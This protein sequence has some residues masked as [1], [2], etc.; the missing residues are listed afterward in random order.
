MGRA[1]QDQ[2]INDLL[3]WRGKAKNNYSGKFAHFLKESES[4]DVDIETLSRASITF[5]VPLDFFLDFAL[6][7]ESGSFE[8]DFSEHQQFINQGIQN[9]L[10]DRERR[11]APATGKDLEDFEANYT[12]LFPG[13]VLRRF[14]QRLREY[15]KSQTQDDALQIAVRRIVNAPAQHHHPSASFKLDL[16]DAAKTPPNLDDAKTPTNS[17]GAAKVDYAQRPPSKQFLVGEHYCAAVTGPPGWTVCL[18]EG[19]NDPFVEGQ[20]IV[21]N[22]VNGAKLSVGKGGTVIYSHEG[23]FVEPTGSFRMAAILVPPRVAGALWPLLRPGAVFP[24]K[25]LGRLGQRAPSADAEF[26][27]LS[28]TYGVIP[29]RT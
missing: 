27:V 29:P 3:G 4:H 14:S 12:K 20:W 17:R 7:S 10:K 13:F 26:Q 24:K 18:V 9:F 25:L 16:V 22:D 23:V 6:A 11:N 21:V 1:L 15:R 8:Q 28:L 2:E 5:D 19:Y